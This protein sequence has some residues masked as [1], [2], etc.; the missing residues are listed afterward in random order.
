MFFS[1]RTLE[2]GRALPEKICVLFRPA[3]A[4]DVC[5]FPKK[6]LISGLKNILNFFFI[7]GDK[8]HFPRYVFFACFFSSPS[9]T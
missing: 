9:L 7:S 8:K 5:R 6:Q 3:R 4:L 1:L 2:L